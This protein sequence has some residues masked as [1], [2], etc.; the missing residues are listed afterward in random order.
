MYTENDT[1]GQL[2]TKRN[3]ENMFIYYVPYKEI[4]ANLFPWTKFIQNIQTG[5]GS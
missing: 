1:E 4:V 5:L 3:Y 2:A